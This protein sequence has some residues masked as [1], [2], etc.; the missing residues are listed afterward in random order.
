MFIYYQKIKHYVCIFITVN[1][2]IINLTFYICLLHYFIFKVN[3]LSKIG[4]ENLR[5]LVL[6][7]MKRIFVVT[8]AKEYSWYGK[9]QNK[10][11]SDLKLCSVIISEYV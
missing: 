2:I 8:V 4:G 5:Q 11:F 10:T 1:K 7:L 6:N 3:K 9:K